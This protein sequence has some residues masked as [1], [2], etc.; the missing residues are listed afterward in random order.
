MALVSAARA[1]SDGGYHQHSTC[2]AAHEDLLGANMAICC[3]APS[4][5]SQNMLDPCSHS[6]VMRTVSMAIQAH[7][8]NFASQCVRHNR[9]EVQYNMTELRSDSPYKGLARFA[10]LEVCVVPALGYAPFH[11]GL[12]ASQT[13]RPTRQG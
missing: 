3:V 9:I 4:G 8:Q 11:Y 7:V 12:S 5:L 10:S 1:W 13:Q 6:A 2:Y